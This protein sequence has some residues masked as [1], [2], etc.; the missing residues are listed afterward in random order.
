MTPSPLSGR[1]S[2]PGSMRWTSMTCGLPRCVALA[3][4]WS[5]G[6]LGAASAA[7]S[8]CRSW[9]VP[10][11]P[12]P[13]CS[14]KLRLSTRMSALN[15]ALCILASDFHRP[16]AQAEML[17]R[18]VV[19]GAFVK[20]WG[21][22][23]LIFAFFS[24]A[25]HGAYLCGGGGSSVPGRFPLPSRPLAACVHLVLF[26]GF[27]GAITLENAKDRV[28]SVE[29]A[30]DTGVHALEGLFSKVAG[31]LAMTEEDARFFSGVRFQ[32]SVRKV[33]GDKPGIK[34]LSFSK[35]NTKKAGGASGMGFDQF[36]FPC[37]LALCRVSFAA[38]G[39]ALRAGVFA[40]LV[41]Q[42]ATTR[43]RCR[44]SGTP[45]RGLVAYVSTTS[46]TCCGP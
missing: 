11:P 46:L 3:L 9:I 38:R 30:I 17:G 35:G 34:K 33:V 4:L 22:A 1:R 26:A 2:P 43:K 15:H 5:R 40:L 44:L 36:L 23:Y 10:S 12:L 18:V 27:A 41:Q 39:R 16:A 45:C 42:A 29:L 13:L 32:E 6:R 25:G 28:V 20:P 24:T 31:T 19:A 37:A 8:T 7:V 14:A 21:V